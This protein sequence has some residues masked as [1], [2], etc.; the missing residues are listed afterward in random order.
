MRRHLTIHSSL[1]VLGLVF[2]TLLVACDAG[3]EMD[4]RTGSGGTSTATPAGGSSSSGGS[5]NVTGSSGVG[6]STGTAA[7][8][9]C[10]AATPEEGF[11]DVPVT[12]PNIR[13][14]GRVH[15]T[16]EA[17]AFAFPAVQIQTV[18]EG[19]AIDMKLRDHGLQNPSATNFY[20]IIVDG[21]E[22]KVQVC[23]AREIYPLARNLGAGPHTLTIVKRTE[24]GPGGQP[25]TGK[26]EFLGFRVRTGTALRQVTQ[27]TRLLEFVGD[28]ITCGYGNEISTTDPD[29]YKFTSVNE[30]AWNAYGA[31]TARALNADYVAV[32]ASGRGVIRNYDGFAGALVPAIYELTLH[33]DT[34]AP[35]WDHSTYSPD[36][37]VVNLGTNDFSPGI[38]LDQMGT[39]RTAFKQGYIDFLTR[40]RAVHAT[41]SI[42]AVV[43]TMMGDSWPEGYNAWT[44]VQADVKAAVEARNAASDPQVHFLALTPQSSPYGEDWHP[45]VATHQ[46]MADTLVPFITSVRGW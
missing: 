11:V 38:A 2:A 33:E 5:S 18:F 26:G 25:N 20:W 39:H 45:T 40:I 43:G 34:S 42:V 21:V 3:S 4:S 44:S 17:V 30:D 35:V 23:P 22:T 29:S 37:I 14:V 7:Q 19:D 8:T 10:T 9:V 24:S 27:S 32:A 41:A 13:Y 36:V 16:A 31:I 28:S 12:D 6:N 1:S 46:K 15:K